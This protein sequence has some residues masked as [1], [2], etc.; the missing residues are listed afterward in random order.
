MDSAFKNVC[1]TASLAAN[2]PIYRS[3]YRAMMKSQWRSR[4]ALAAERAEK[5]S[6]LLRY[7][8]ERV[9]FYRR[10]FRAAGKLPE[11][12]RTAD[13]L[14]RLP[15]L[16]KSALNANID[17]LVARDYPPRR[18]LLYSTGGSTG[19]PTRFYH[20]ATEMAWTEAAVNRSYNWAGYR[21]GE[22]FLLVSGLPG[23]K[24]SIIG[25]LRRLQGQRRISLFGAGEREIGEAVDYI[26]RLR[27]RGIKGYVSWLQIIARELTTRK[28]SWRPDHVITSSEKL[29]PEARAVLREGFGVEPFE[30]YSSREFMLAAECEQHQGLHIAAENVII[31]TVRDGKPVEPGEW[32][33]I[34]VTD[35]NRYGM[36]LIRYAIGDVGVLS[37]RACPC[38]RGLPILEEVVGRVSD[39]IRTQEGKL[40]AA[41]AVAH[42]F[43][44][45]P[46]KKFR[47]IQETEEELTIRVI[48]APGYAS[49]HEAHINKSFGGIEVRIEYVDDIPVPPSGKNVIV[50]SRIKNI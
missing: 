6:S 48:K 33:E 16:E 28:T 23:E 4:E 30:N 15:V 12:I 43:K 44:D 36:P 45:L 20:D 29:T 22:R 35:L 1:R 25:R 18:L 10:M 13:D 34:L 39:I 38:G 14:P 17:N 47:V 37:E 19:L 9:P 46:V 49:D 32:G 31:E 2:F 26:L 41:P 42:I 50:E 7:A 3:A 27:P 11:D 8:W 40:I 21:Q 5:L 24:A